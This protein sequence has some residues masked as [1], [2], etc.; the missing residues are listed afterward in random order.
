MLVWRG[1]RA[2]VRA[3][4]FSPD[5]RFITTTAGTSQFVW[6]WEA[7]TGKLVRKL[8]HGYCA[9]A[10]AFYPDGEHI[11]AT[12]EHGN[13]TIWETETGIVAAGLHSRGEGQYPDA[14]A[15]SP[16]GTRVFTCTHYG[17][18]KLLEWEGS[19]RSASKT[20]LPPDHRH[21][22]LCRGTPRIGF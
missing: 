5:G 7:S 20:D 1:H 18:N 21:D 17:T 2:K 9:R 16:D 22:K 10:V 4:S 12:W 11:A 15:V 3:L 14:L 19:L 13:V 6:L 8:R